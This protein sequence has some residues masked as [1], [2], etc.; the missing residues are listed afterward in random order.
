MSGYSLRDSNVHF[1][2]QK[3]LSAV[4]KRLECKIKKKLVLGKLYLEFEYVSV[5]VQYSLILIATSGL[6][7]S[8]QISISCPSIS[9]SAFDASPADTMNTGFGVARF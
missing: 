7:K 6:N 3:L 9:A 5:L 4:F 8:L 2:T 1:S